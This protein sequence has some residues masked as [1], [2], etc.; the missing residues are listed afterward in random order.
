MSTLLGPLDEALIKDIRGPLRK[1][2][3]TISDNYTRQ[4]LLALHGFRNSTL[5]KQRAVSQGITPRLE[6]R[7]LAYPSRVSDREIAQQLN[8]A[9][10][11]VS[12][13]R[14]GTRK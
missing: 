7:I 4:L 2:I 11:N 8:V 13:I 9:I 3:N 6:R 12:C 10:H 14:R 5:G 1:T